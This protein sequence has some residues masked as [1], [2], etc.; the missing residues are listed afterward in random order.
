[1]N[2]TF[3]AEVIDTSISYKS[4][5]DENNVTYPHGA[6][7][8]RSR[9][10]G[11]SAIPYEGVAVPLSINDFE[12]PLVGEHIMITSATS[13]ESS[14]FKKR[15]TFYYTKVVN[16]QDNVNNNILPSVNAFRADGNLSS[17]YRSRSMSNAS[18]G[19]TEQTIQTLLKTHTVDSNVTFLQPF[20]GDRILQ[21]R[22]GAGIRFSSTIL[23]NT[24]IYENVPTWQGTKA[25]DPVLVLSAGIT[26]NNRYYTIENIDTDKSSIYI[27][28]NQK[29]SLTSKP[30]YNTI[31]PIS[32]YTGAQVIIASDRLVFASKRD[33]I[34]LSS[35]RTV[36]I[37]TA[38][39]KADMDKLFTLLEQTLQ[40]LADLTS[41]KA[42]FQ[43]PMGGPTLT[44]TNVTEVQKL[45][46]E[47]KT[48]K[49]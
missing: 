47:L 31:T 37:S 6:I 4:S 14:V 10:G 26:N 22:Y 21:S 19:I 27:F 36:G 33:S 7:K 43:T 39:W 2:N 40:A 18:N 15:S 3:S 20:E 8:F 9:P 12:M 44:A 5:T 25:N 29:L 49:Q 42:Q 46:T 24:S 35:E 1:M 32:S 13:N 28:S 34:I 48:M 23:G 17:N 11:T 41:G 30:V 16:I 38:N 45:L